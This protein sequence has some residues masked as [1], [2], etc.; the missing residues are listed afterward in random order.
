MAIIKKLFK[1]FDFD[2]DNYR[3]EE[4]VWNENLFAAVDR[5]YN[6]EAEDIINQKQSEIFSKSDFENLEQDV[7]DRYHDLSVDYLRGI[8]VNSSVDPFEGIDYKSIISDNQ[9]AQ[10]YAE[11]HQDDWKDGRHQFEDSSDKIDDLFSS[12]EK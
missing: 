2:Y 11:A 10:E 6:A 12:L 5:I 1:K 7:F 9:E 3:I 4:D 8:E